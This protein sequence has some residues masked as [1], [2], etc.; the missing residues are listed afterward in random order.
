MTRCYGGSL[1]QAS[2]RVLHIL[3]PCPLV[4]NQHTTLS[5]FIPIAISHRWLV[6]N[7]PY[8]SALKILLCIDLLFT[9][10]VVFSSGRQ[11]LKNALINEKMKRTDEETMSMALSRT[12]VTGGAVAACFG[13]SQV[14]GFGVVANLVGGVAQGTLAFIIPPAIAIS[15][16]RRRSDGEFDFAEISQWLIGA[17]GAAVVLSVTYFTLAES[18]R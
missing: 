16:S 12:A 11:I 4:S 9:F 1:K 6:D 2:D 17:F 7:G 5:A 14:G 8:L 10:P 18:L 3:S 15:L 13:L